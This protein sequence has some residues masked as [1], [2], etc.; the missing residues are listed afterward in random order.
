MFSWIWGSNNTERDDSEA[1]RHV[2]DVVLLHK[3]GKTSNAT[4][5]NIRGCERTK[6]VQWRRRVKITIRTP[7]ECTEED[8]QVYIGDDLVRCLILNK[9]FIELP[10]LNKVDTTRSVWSH[11]RNKLS[12]SLC[13]DSESCGQWSHLV[14]IPSRESRSWLSYDWDGHTE[15]DEEVR[16]KKSIQRQA[17][18]QHQETAKYLRMYGDFLLRYIGQSHTSEKLFDA[19]DL[20]LLEKPA[21]IY[22]RRTRVRPKPRTA[23]QLFADTIQAAG[24]EL[25]RPNDTSSCGLS[26]EDEAVPKVVPVA[27]QVEE[28]P[29]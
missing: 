5:D 27:T 20:I 21:T 18:R 29:T 14:S 24:I 13:K 23:A 12:I 8:I 15:E 28:T 26:S 9:F 3:G 1:W 25:P 7:E 2:S 4:Y 16:M 19:D 17:M 22:Q 11:G 10:L 6:W